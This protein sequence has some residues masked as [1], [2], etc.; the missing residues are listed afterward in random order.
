MQ[1][2]AS[3]REGRLLS[4]LVVVVEGAAHLLGPLEQGTWVVL[5]IMGSREKRIERGTRGRGWARTD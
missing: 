5:E 3:D 4:H 2:L 1:A